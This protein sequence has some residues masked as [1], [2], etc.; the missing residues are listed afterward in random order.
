MTNAGDE[1]VERLAAMLRQ[2]AVRAD[3]LIAA[4]RKEGGE[5]YNGSIKRLERQLRRTQ[6]DLEDLE[7]GLLRTA[8]STLRNV[9]EAAHDHPYAAAGATMILGA[10]VGLLV[11][12]AVSRR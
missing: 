11:G 1:G 10:F 6:A 12:M 5:R 4:V 2:V 9:D 8:R 3:D 7:E